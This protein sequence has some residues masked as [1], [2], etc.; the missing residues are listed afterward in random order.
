M[1]LEKSLNLILTNG[2]EPCI[3]HRYLLLNYKLAVIH[4]LRF[5]LAFFT[6]EGN[7]CKCETVECSVYYIMLFVILK[8]DLEHTL[9]QLVV[10]DDDDD[11]ETDDDSEKP[12]H[13]VPIVCSLLPH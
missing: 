12:T 4:I 1:V 8:S 3:V 6:L 2:Q 5:I 13:S 11:D 9:S 7:K 10:D